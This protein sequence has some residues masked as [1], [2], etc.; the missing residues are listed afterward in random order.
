MS[1]EDNKAP[2]AEKGTERGHWHSTP[3]NVKI[4]M[5]GDILKNP[6]FQEIVIKNLEAKLKMDLSNRREEILLKLAQRL[7]ELLLKDIVEERKNI[8]KMQEGGETQEEQEIQEIQEIQDEDED[9]DDSDFVFEDDD[10]Q[11][12]DDDYDSSDEDNDDMIAPA[13]WS[14]KLIIRDALLSF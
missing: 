3:L 9:E 8:R 11:P 12:T 14:L 2:A 5:I 10:E 6:D 7:A 1:S 13:A 4:A